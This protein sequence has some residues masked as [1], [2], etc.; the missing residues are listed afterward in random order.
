MNR[1]KR[2]LR[3]AL[4]T[5][6][7][8]RR[9]FP[10][11]IIEHITAKIAEVERTHS[12]E[13]VFAVE[14]HLD[15]VDLLRNKSARQRALELFSSL[16]VWDTEAN[17]GVLIYV[18]LADRDVEL[19]ADRGVDIHVGREVWNEVCRKMED[20]FRAC[21]YEG[22]VFLAIE[23]VSSHLARHFPKNPEDINKLSNKPVMI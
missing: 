16:R 7:H 10:P 8:A 4:S 23:E 20:C 5:R 1:L 21:D 3:H 11:L 13:I 18:L 2:I 6:F 22:G 19:V 17:N 14:A 9:A 12:G 15:P